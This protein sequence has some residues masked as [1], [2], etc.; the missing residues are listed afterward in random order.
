MGLRDMLR[1]KT[2]SKKAGEATVTEN[3]D[4]VADESPDDIPFGLDVWVEGVDP[5]VEYISL[6]VFYS[7]T[8][9]IVVLGRSIVAIHGLN[10]HREKTWTAKN[11]V[12]WLRDANM[13]STIIPNA[14]IMSW[15]YDAN[16]HS[17]EGLS[18]MYL[19]DHAQNLVSDLSLHRRRDKVGKLFIVTDS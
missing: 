15:G 7:L 19:Y 18:A 2:G 13:L 16:T 12:N 6:E 11:K 4:V 1:K 9:L 10:G 3:T 14:R 17:T 8:E 5:I